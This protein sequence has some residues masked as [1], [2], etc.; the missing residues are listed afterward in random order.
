MSTFRSMPNTTHAA[1]MSFS[2]LQAICRKG[3]DAVYRR[4]GYNKWADTN[5]II[6]LYPQTDTGRNVATS[7]PESKRVLGLVGFHETRDAE[8]RFRA[9]T[10]EQISAIRKMSIAS[11]KDQCTQEVLPTPSGYLKISRVAD[12]TSTSVALI[13]QANNAATG[14]NIYRSIVAPDLYEKKQ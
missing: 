4:G 13:W 1:C 5:Q 3:G 11:L 8:Q 10:G 6:V 14:F 7:I 2:R 12:I 9:K